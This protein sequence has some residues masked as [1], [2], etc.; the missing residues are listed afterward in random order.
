MVGGIIMYWGQTKRQEAILPTQTTSSKDSPHASGEF[1]HQI[2]ALIIYS[3]VYF[4]KLQ[5]VH[6]IPIDNVWLNIERVTDLE[7]IKDESF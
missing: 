3:K 2:L 1:G 5:L 6:Q 7:R 4:W